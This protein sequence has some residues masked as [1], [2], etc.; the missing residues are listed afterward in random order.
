MRRDFCD[1]LDDMVSN[2]EDIQSYVE[3]K[4]IDDLI[5]NSQLK[6]AVLF[7][8]QIIG[9]AS[10]KIP[11]SVREKYP[12]VPWQKV[13]DF[14]NHIVQAYFNINAALVWAIL[15]DHLEPLKQQFQSVFEYS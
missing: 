9:E 6:K 10:G 1:Y 2:I 8:L 13:K 7:S 15:E 14:R 11:E 4:S 3:G 5:E 12:N